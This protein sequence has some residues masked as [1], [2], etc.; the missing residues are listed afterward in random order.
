MSKYACPQPA[1]CDFENQEYDFCS[2]LNTNNSI[3]DFDWEHHSSDDS[4]QFG[5]IPD[6]TLEDL[7]GHFALSNGKKYQHYSR[8][9]SENLPATSE[10]GACLTFYYYYNGGSGYNLTVRLAEY[11]SSDISLWSL[12]DMQSI[13]KFWRLGRIY[14][15]TRDTYRIYFDGYAG[16]DPKHF[17]GKSQYIYF[18]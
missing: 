18:K 17:V 7:S 2:W 5:S 12:T 6:S 11:N 1:N 16:S 14:Y 9:F 4:A 10:N 3:D 13:T 15:K 8:L